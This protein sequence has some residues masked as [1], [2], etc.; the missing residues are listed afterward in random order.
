MKTISVLAG[1][2]LVAKAI[3]QPNKS[4][5]IDCDKQFYRCNIMM[6]FSFPMV[7][8]LKRTI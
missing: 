7:L 3:K 8:V 5:I 4:L 6:F 2:R 1:D